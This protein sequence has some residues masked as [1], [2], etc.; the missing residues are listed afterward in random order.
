[1]KPKIIAKLI[2]LFISS[3]LLSSSLII[4]ALSRICKKQYGPKA[5][6]FPFKMVGLSV[7]H[8]SFKSK[9]YCNSVYIYVLCYSFGEK[10]VE[11]QLYSQVYYCL[12]KRKKVAMWKAR[13]R[14]QRGFPNRSYI[15][16]IHVSTYSYMYVVYVCVH[17]DI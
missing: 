10:M 15:Y 2:S 7:N 12:V 9:L 5:A 11:S 16:Y 4:K 17:M 1:M 8:F 3:I 6:F 14:D 13:L